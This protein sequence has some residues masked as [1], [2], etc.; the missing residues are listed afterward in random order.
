MQDVSLHAGDAIA[1]YAAVVATGSVVVQLYESRR[2]RRSVVAVEFTWAMLAMSDGSTPEAVMIGGDQQERPSSPD[3]ERRVLR[4]GRLGR[5]DRRPS[6]ST[7]GDHPGEVASHDSGSTHFRRTD[8]EQ[9]VDLRKPLVAFVN[10]AT[11]EK[12]RSKSR[13]LFKD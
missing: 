1:I 10:L 9:L 11:G 12:I 5:H 13:T 7:W 8:L 6:G 4:A 2:K 3:D